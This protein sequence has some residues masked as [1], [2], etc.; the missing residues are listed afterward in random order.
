MRPLA[1]R[2]WN[3]WRQRPMSTTNT[4]MTAK[5]HLNF[6]TMGHGLVVRRVT[7]TPALRIALGTRYS[8]RTKKCSNWQSAWQTGWQ[9]SQA[10][11]K[12]KLRGAESTW[13]DGKYGIELVSW[14]FSFVWANKTTFIRLRH[15]DY[16]PRHIASQKICD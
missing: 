14:Q 5:V 12:W 1:K 4:P 16:L 8:F 7:P 3:K 15:V 11:E 2:G 13:K 10:S 6:L 9:L